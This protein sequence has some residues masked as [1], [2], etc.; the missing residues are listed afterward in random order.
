MSSERPHAGLG[1]GD[2]VPAVPPGPAPLPPAT[3]SGADIAIGVGIG[4]GVPVVLFFLWMMV[5]STPVGVSIPF[6]LQRLLMVSLTGI[7]IVQLLWI[8]PLAI[9]AKAAHHAA[10]F[11]GLL[12]GASVVFLLNAACFALVFAALGRVYG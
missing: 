8:A 10:L 6:A 2:A 7:G 1:P 4:V 9:W 11:K 5:T 12:I 3:G